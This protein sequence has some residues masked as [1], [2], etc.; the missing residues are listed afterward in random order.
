VLWDFVE[1]KAYVPQSTIAPY[2]YTTF[3][4]VGPDGAEIRD[5]LMIIVR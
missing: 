3:P 5:G 1:K 4:V 2:D